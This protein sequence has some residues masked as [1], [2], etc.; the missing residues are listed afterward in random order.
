MLERP[1]TIARPWGEFRQYT[2]N[3][4]VTVKT[5]F[6]KAGSTLSL[7]YHNHRSEF[8]RVMRGNPDITIGEEKIK[9]KPG[10]EF[11]IPQ[12]VHHRIGARDEDVEILEIARGEFDEEDIIRI[13]DK[14]GRV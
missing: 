2:K 11:E 7:Q 9:G 5:V 1:F 13:E 10:D 8:W 12:G 3:D 14:Y 4:P 6:I